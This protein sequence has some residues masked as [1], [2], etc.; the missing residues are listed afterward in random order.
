LDARQS[1]RFCASP[2]STGLIR[3]Q[4]VGNTARLIVNVRRIRHD[5]LVGVTWTPG[6]VHAGEVIASVRVVHG[7]TIERTLRFFHAPYY[8]RRGSSVLLTTNSGRIVAH[9]KPC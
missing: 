5:G 6:R 4:T 8:R 7:S 1:Q 9:A 2:P 3:Y